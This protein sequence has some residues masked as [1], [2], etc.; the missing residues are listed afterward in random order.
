MWTPA[1]RA[2]LARESL[3]YA[4]S[5]TDAEWRVVAPL[6]PSPAVTGRPWR[7]P[8]RLVLDAVLYVSCGP[9]AR[10]GTCRTSSRRGPPCTAGFC[11]CRARPC[12]N[13]S[14]MLSRWPIGNG[15]DARPT[16]PVRS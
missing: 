10:G 5:L 16:R 4:T 14:P 9:A 11:A 15:S 1:A 7:W 13:V 2:E 8:T 6:L 12:S 3:P